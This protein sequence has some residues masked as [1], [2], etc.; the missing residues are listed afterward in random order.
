MSST[1][2][3]ESILSEEKKEDKNYNTIDENSEKIILST[4]KQV[5]LYDPS[6]SPLSKIDQYDKNLSN[7]IQTLE[8]NSIIEF[9][10]YIFARLFN[11]DLMISYFIILFFYHFYY[12][13]NYTFII[14]PLIHVLVTLM[15]TLVTKSIFKRPRPNIKENVK[16]IFNCRNKETNYSMPS[17]DS[18]QSANFAILTL[19]YLGNFFG[20]ILIPFVMFARIFYFCHYILD[21]VIGT[22]IGLCVSWAL[23]YPL[24]LITA[25]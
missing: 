10:I 12:Y 8:V 20:F 22:L 2:E 14:K 15:I 19:F 6:Q 23:V 7:Y 17:G 18:M 21:T 16:R 5:K 11:P 3:T 25:F 1:E 13:N 24:R 9:I 4:E